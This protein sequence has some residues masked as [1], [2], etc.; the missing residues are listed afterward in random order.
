MV[1]SE[2]KKRLCQLN[3]YSTFLE[4][5]LA[6]KKQNIHRILCKPGSWVMSFQ[7]TKSQ[8]L[9]TKTAERRINTQKTIS[10]TSRIN[11]ICKETK[12]VNKKQAQIAKQVES[13]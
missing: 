5:H 11:T 13:G 4:L 6:Q 10:Q 9:S 1:P 7:V 12:R 8:R 3:F 2:K